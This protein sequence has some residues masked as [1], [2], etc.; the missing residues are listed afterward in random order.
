MAISSDQIPELMRQNIRAYFGERGMDW[1][2]TLPE[3]LGGIASRWSIQIG[4]PFPDLSINFV[5]PGVLEDGTELV[6]KAGVPNREISTEI[7]ALLHFD[8]AG[9][10]RVL[11]SDAE[12][13]VMLL[14]RLSPGTSLIERP[15]DSQ[16]IDIAVGVM[17]RLW[18]A[19]PDEH[20]FPD[21]RDWFTGLTEV[22]KRFDG[23]S[24][25]LP[26]KLFEMAESLA[27]DLLE[28]TEEPVLLH[29]DCHHH[30][31]LDAG[32]KGWLV[33]DPKGVVGERAFEV[34]P[35][36][37]NPPG[38][39]EQ[40]WTGQALERRVIQFSERTAIERER[41]QAWGVAEAVLSASWD[42]DNESQSWKGTIAI[43]EKYV[44]MM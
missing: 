16:A 34:A 23:T 22:R 19:P 43:A 13:G 10:V 40:L 30:N 12:A 2:K 18:K 29:G 17:Q 32:Q 39:N 9:A 3:F 1:L 36:L 31:I 37:R 14:E 7:N 38:L 35:F 21:L 6:L 42:L 24:G 20:S 44:E 15:D 5:A 28:S 33:I 8:G 25:P 41:L 27:T 4:D 26:R 11:R